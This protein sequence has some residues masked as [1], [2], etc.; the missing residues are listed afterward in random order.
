MALLLY[1]CNL[2]P[3]LKPEVG[4]MVRTNRHLSWDKYIIP[5]GTTFVV[6]DYDWMTDRIGIYWCR[7]PLYLP[8][9]FFDVANP[10]RSHKE[11]EV[12]CQI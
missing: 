7:V 10:T 2:I 9:E 12:K 1:K 8:A 5:E 4:D 6:E 3:Y 11:K